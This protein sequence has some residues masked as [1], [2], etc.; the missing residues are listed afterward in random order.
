MT[1]TSSGRRLRLITAISLGVIAAAS[2]GLFEQY[3]EEPL[4]AA[5]GES[6]ADR[7]VDEALD[8]MAAAIGELVAYWVERQVLAIRHD[9]ATPPD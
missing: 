4:R 2:V 6:E 1:A 8:S 3:V 7:R 5:A 9:P